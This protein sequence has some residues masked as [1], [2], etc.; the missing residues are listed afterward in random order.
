VGVVENFESRRFD[1]IKKEVKDGELIVSGE[2][3]IREHVAGLGGSFTFCT[4]GEPLEL[5]RLLTG[6]HYHRSKRWV[7]SCS[8][9]PLIRRLML[10]R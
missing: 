2:K 4:L 7:R 1:R 5:D 3:D 10:S 8:T 6:R 9:W